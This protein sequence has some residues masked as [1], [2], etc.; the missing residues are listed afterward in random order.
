M[1]LNDGSSFYTVDLGELKLDDISIEQFFVQNS[2][3]DNALA[4]KYGDKKEFARII[5]GAFE[6]KDAASEAAK[7]LNVSNEK[8]RVSNIKNHQNLYKEFHKTQKISTSSF[9]Y[10]GSDDII[11][12]KLDNRQNRLKEEFFNYNSSFYTITLTTFSKENIDIENYFFK[13]NLTESTLAFSIGSVNNYYRVIHG[14]YETYDEANSAIE[15]LNYELR[16]NSPYVSRIKT[17]QKKFESYNNRT[18]EEEKAK[19]KKIEF[20]EK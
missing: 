1:F 16:K 6:T 12:S 19:A 13:N 15:N 17:Q 11:Y 5:Y 4:Y 18:L 8:P 2:M 7:K 14:V 9:S 10:E 20:S 3:K